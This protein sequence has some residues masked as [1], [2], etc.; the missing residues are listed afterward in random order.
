[1]R[2]PHTSGLQPV[3]TLIICP[4]N[5]EGGVCT[6]LT[7]HVHSTVQICTQ[8]S[9]TLSTQS[10]LYN[11][12]PGLVLSRI[13]SFYLFGTGSVSVPLTAFL[14]GAAILTW[15]TSVYLGFLWYLIKVL[16]SLSNKLRISRDKINIIVSS[17]WN[18]QSCK[19]IYNSVK[20]RCAQ[21]R[22]TAYRG[23][24]L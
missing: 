3:C 13:A 23:L 19:Y 14:F 20:L 8:Y 4:H 24:G 22:Q 16:K 15:T 2:F 11:I 18:F 17:G 9:C 10:G 1:M 7:G 5:G 21:L 6:A 12:W